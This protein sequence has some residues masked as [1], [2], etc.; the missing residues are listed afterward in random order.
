[1]SSTRAH[2]GSCA[3]RQ[4]TVQESAQLCSISCTWEVRKMQTKPHHHSIVCLGADDA[5]HALRRL[6]HSIKCQVIALL[7]LKGLPQV[8]QPGPACHRRRSG[9]LPMSPAST[10]L[11]PQ[12]EVMWTPTLLLVV[13]RGWAVP[14]DAAQCVLVGHP[15][16]D[17]TAPIVPVKVNAL[18][19]LYP[20]P[21]PQRMRREPRQ[22]TLW[23]TS[24]RTTLLIHAV[25]AIHPLGSAI[26]RGDLML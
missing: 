22:P 12:Q 17:H 6:P 23:H 11:G 9:S 13:S 16:H 15:E 24:L 1:M 7:D 10:M 21:T 19:H 20:S 26:S 5:A 2:F 3:G 14:E 25:S 8:L 18:C 4:A